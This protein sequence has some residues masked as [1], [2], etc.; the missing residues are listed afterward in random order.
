M[1]WQTLAFPCLV[2]AVLVGCKGRSGS[3]ESAAAPATP[4]VTDSTSLSTPAAAPTD[5]TTSK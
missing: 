4:G 1:K 5:T 3:N 2:A